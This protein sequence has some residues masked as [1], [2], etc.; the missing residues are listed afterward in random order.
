VLGT[1]KDLIA[2]GPQTVLVAEREVEGK[3]VETLIPFVDAYVDSVSLEGRRI[4]VDW[5][6][7]Y[8]A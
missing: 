7:D 4:T 2:T 8:L 1:V 6:L 3:P 5:Q